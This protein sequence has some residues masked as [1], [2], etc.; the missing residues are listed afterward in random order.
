MAGLVFKKAE[1]SKAKL[2]IGIDGP[3]GAGKTMSALA[4]ATALGKTAVIDTERGSASL[5]ANDFDFEVTELTDFHPEKYIE[6]IE[7]ARKGGFEV[8]VIDSLSHTWAGTNGA[9]E[10]VNTAQKR[11][12]GGNSFTAWREVTPLYNKLIDTILSCPMHVICT[13]RTKVDYVIDQVDSGGRSKSAPRKVGLAP[14]MREGLDYEMTVYGSMNL[15]HE[16]IIEK[17]RISAL[18]NK[19]FKEPGAQFAG[20]LMDW[21]NS[22]KDPIDKNQDDLMWEHR[23]SSAQN[24]EELQAMQPELAKL[25]AEKKAKYAPVYKKRLAELP[26]K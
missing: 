25:D 21:L 11:T 20:I 3:A 13:L 19:I 8:V 18:S 14:V 10:L 7:A 5:Y 22:A 6:A 4:I 16:L 23:I 12:G 26:K 2:R 9:L 1:K 15:D 24:I 17:T